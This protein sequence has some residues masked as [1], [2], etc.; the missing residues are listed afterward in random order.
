MRLFE[1]SKLSLSELKAS[2]LCSQVTPFGP[3]NS[4]VQKRWLKPVISAQI[5]LEDR[6]RD[7]KLDKLTTHLKKLDII[8]K[9]HDLM[10]SRKRGPFVSL[11]LMSRWRNLVGLNVGIGAFVHKYPHVFEVFKHPV[12][13]SLCCRISK[14]MRGLIE[15]EAM[16]MK[17]WELKVVHRVKK[18]LMMSVSGT[19]RVHALRLVRREFG[20][21]EDFRE[22]ILGKYSKDFRLIDLEV[23]EPISRD[24]NLG[25]A[26][27]EKWREKEFKEKWLSE[28]ET[29][30]A[31]PINFPTGYEI[32]AGFRDMLK[33]WQRL[34]YVKPYD[35]KEV[36]R[37][38]TCG[39]IESYEKRAVGIL[40]EFLS[41]TVEKM[42][43]VER[44]FHFR[45]DFSMDVNVRELI[46]KHPGIFYI[47][48]RRN[49]QTVFLREAY[50]KGCLIESNPIY[51]VR[52]KTLDL[53]F[54]GRR[55]T[56]QMPAPKEIKEFKVDGDG[57]MDG[58]WVIPMLENLD[59][60]S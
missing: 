28:F 25:V 42:V 26:E 20:L 48:T 19:L 60:G 41:L 59:N 14:K 23:V 9:L 7:S 53:V 1:S 47:S 58:D 36:V 40:H 39:G 29:K 16:A 51:D 35:R 17:Q 32:Q 6:T 55:N 50:S 15:E 57:K 52:R 49:S 56:R 43:E 44:L 18:L 37:I 54:L 24:E 34:P 21:P 13:R 10:S 45:R 31:F 11:Q 33:N 3:F 30:Y 12:R 22:S 5:R 2:V 46:L 27:I 8:L 38:R 4:F